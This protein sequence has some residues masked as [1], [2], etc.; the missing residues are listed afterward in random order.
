MRDDAGMSF[1]AHPLTLRQLQYVVAVS[2]A[3]SFRKA[4]EL[5]AVSQPALSAQIAQIESA[6]G[7]L[8]FERTTRRVLPTAAGAVFIQKARALL[9]GA[10]ALVAEARRS[11]DPLS[12]SLRLG[13]IPTVGP[14]LLPEVMQ[15]LRLEFPRLRFE[16]VEERT[17]VLM[18]DLREGRL[19]GALVALEAELLDDAVSFVI[20]KDPFFLATSKEHPLARSSAP[21]DLASLDDEDVL[22]LDEGHC[23]RHQVL[24]VCARAR[25]RGVDVRATSLTTL[26]Q[27]ALVWRNGSGAHQAL[28][29]VGGLMRKELARSR[30]SP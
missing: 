14:Y 22:V 16:W 5:C 25:V 17:Q 4:A 1:S 9:S 13:V 2:D 24:G 11:A 26:A 15:P 8:L 29:A 20:G 10:D 12:G 21:I 23:F 7:L 30:S 6:I 19:D 28:R 3:R 18:R 27:L